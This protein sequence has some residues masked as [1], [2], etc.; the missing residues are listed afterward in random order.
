MLAMTNP[1]NPP[2]VEFLDTRQV[3][4]FARQSYAT[5]KRRQREGHDT[6]LR[7]HGRRVVFH[8]DTLRRFLAGEA[9]KATN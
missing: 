9:T 1:V 2:Q 6:G 5:L 3:E 8:V 4:A 7:K